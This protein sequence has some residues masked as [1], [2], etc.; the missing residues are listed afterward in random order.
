MKKTRNVD[1][2]QQHQEKHGSVVLRTIMA[3]AAVGSVT[4]LALS[5][6]KLVQDPT[7]TQGTGTQ[8]SVDAAAAQFVC[9]NPILPAEQ[10]TEIEIEGVNSAAVK[11]TSSA[12]VAVAQG[13]GSVEYSFLQSLRSDEQEQVGEQ[14]QLAHLPAKTTGD[15]RT[16]LVKAPKLSGALVGQTKARLINDASTGQYTTMSM[17]SS[18]DGGTNQG[19]AAAA[20]TIPTAETWLVG[21]S[22][23]VGSAST[24]LII[25]NPSKTPA[26]VKITIWGPSGKVAL[27][28]SDSLLI[29][30]GTQIEK[31]LDSLAPEQRRLVVHVEAEGAL[32]SSYLKLSEIE[33]ITPGGIE[34][35]TGSAA[36]SRAQ[37]VPVMQ[38]PANTEA[39]SAP[40][41]VRL[42]VPDFRTPQDL[43]EQTEQDAAHITQEVVGTATIYLLGSE[44]NVVMFGGE[45]V[46]LIAGQVQ[47]IDLSSVP[48][49]TYSVVVDATVPLS[50][51]VRS[52]VQGATDPSQPL[53]GAARDF[54]WSGAQSVYSTNHFDSR[55]DLET[56]NS[57]LEPIGLELTTQTMDNMVALPDA[58][59]TKVVVTSLPQVQSAQ[60]LTTSLTAIPRVYVGSDQSDASEQETDEEREHR[61]NWVAQETAVVTVWDWQGKSIRTSQLPLAPGQSKMLDLK[62]LTGA[63]A[64]S[65]TSSNGTPIAWGIVASATA[66]SGS[67]TTLQPQYSQQEP[68]DVWVARTQQVTH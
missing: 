58:L 3:L 55:S 14:P 46:E 6:D 45:P 49:G 41:A 56:W 60:D 38:V 51:A 17:M 59:T 26:T 57:N 10:D 35:V 65:V 47:D 27:A 52:N 28:G 24:S 68:T 63:A 15:T 36:P 39:Q 2:S 25:Q 16:Q 53:I 33:G 21:G 64:V 22:T 34:F 67:I 9:P 11:N 54:G 48:A 29:A 30:P 44:G 43:G 1:P 40:P 5:G 31:L 37:V 66:V 8:V 61:E 4:A 62:G 50:A 13:T 20:C 23:E 7:T 18:N 32:I 12:S 19:L 42:V